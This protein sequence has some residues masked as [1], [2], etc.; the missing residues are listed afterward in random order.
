MMGKYF[1][2]ILQFREI[3]LFWSVLNISKSLTL[4][5]LLQLSFAKF[6][7]ILFFSVMRCF[8]LFFL[9]N[10]EGFLSSQFVVLLG[11]NF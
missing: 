5:P 9:V 2:L 6:L 4:L 7:Y 10:Q 11:V 8:M 1:A 3:N